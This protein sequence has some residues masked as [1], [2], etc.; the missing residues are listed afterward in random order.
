MHLTDG[1]YAPDRRQIHTDQN[2][3][4]CTG[5]KLTNFTE[6][7]PSWESNPTVHY[8][9]H[10]NLQPVPIISKINLVNAPH[11]TSWRS[12]LISSHHLCLGL[13][14]CLLPS[15]LSTKILYSPLLSPTCATCPTHLIL[16][17]LITQIFGQYR[18]QSVSLCCLSHCP[19]TL[20]LIGPNIF[21]S[22]LFP[23]TL[24]LRYLFTVGDQVSHPYKTK[25]KI[26]VLYLDLHSF[27]QQTG[28]QKI[29]QW[30][31]ASIAW[32]Q[33]ALKFLHE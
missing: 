20:S 28:R 29:L 19:L 12:I 27:G 5:K 10:K 4:S 26:I 18:S 2:N 13:P 17:D 33:S 31:I 8:R 16:L 9:I 22:T 11:P 24:S 21:L 7:S 15:G 30:I 23:N 3:I 14:S 25:G 1:R 6:K 32:L